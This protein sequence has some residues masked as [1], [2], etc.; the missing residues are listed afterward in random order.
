MNHKERV[1][2]SVLWAAW[3]DAMGF[4]TE[5]AE[6][7]TVTWRT[8]QPVVDRT[9]PWRRQVGGKF[10]ATVEF[11]AG[12]YSDDTQ[13][14][15]ATSRSIRAGGE[16]DVEAFAKVEL[17][18]FLNYALGAGKGTRGAATNLGRAGVTW[19]TNFFAGSSGQYIQG[20]GNGA[21]MRVQPHVW[22]ATPGSDQWLAPAL[23]N[24]ITTHGHPRG[25]LGAVLHAGVLSGV[26]NGRKMGTIGDCEEAL[27][28]IS[29]IPEVVAADDELEW[30]WRPNWETATGVTLGAAVEETLAELTAMMQVTHMAL[31]SRDPYERVV[32]EL[33]ARE[34][35]QRGSGTVTTLI[36]TALF[37]LAQND[38]TEAMRQAV[39]VLGTDTDTIATMAGALIGADGVE[40]P[41]NVG[42]IQD[43]DFLR[44]EA[45]RLSAIAH[46]KALTTFRYPDLIRWPTSKSALDLVGTNQDGVGLA[47]LGALE[48]RGDFIASRSRA[49]EGWQWCRLPFGQTVLVKRRL[50]LR[51]LPVGAIADQG[52][53]GSDPSPNAQPSLFTATAPK[54]KPKRARAKKP[55]AQIPEIFA[56]S[57]SA[58]EVDIKLA[59]DRI[60]GSGFPADTIGETLKQIALTPSGPTKVTEFANALALAIRAR[61]SAE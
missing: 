48:S 5:L 52:G 12:T 30:F 15:L 54:Q 25:F 19:C 38:P 35:S 2:A 45:N 50:R 33:G 40:F 55:Q 32:S 21:A 43:E 18:T 20:G 59:I 22:A 29:R 53:A 37:L 16:F 27:H 8:G 41:P 56:P 13:L 26:L 39:N 17:P 61:A 11:P 44:R 14:R 58:D 47:G 60:V 6:S 36:A 3:S 10:G 57:L 31:K 46:G 34:P 9:V 28:A 4:M 7:S 49:E 51:P 24:A 23:R 42:A 1:L